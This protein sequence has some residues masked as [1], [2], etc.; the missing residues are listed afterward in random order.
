MQ[1]PQSQAPHAVSSLI[2]QYADMKQCAKV[3]ALRQKHLPTI[4]GRPEGSVTSSAIHSTQDTR[5]AAGEL[6]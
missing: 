3:Y 4:T 2:T 1:L 6:Q 5:A